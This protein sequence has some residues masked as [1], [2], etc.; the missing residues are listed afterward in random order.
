MFK[1]IQLYYQFRKEVDRVKLKKQAVAH[2]KFY[3]KR[4]GIP[5]WT[6]EYQHTFAV[7]VERYMQAAIH[8]YAKLKLKE[9][10]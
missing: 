9:Q 1:R 7:H 2:T 4:Q 10:Q 3:F 8:H 6:N 5:N